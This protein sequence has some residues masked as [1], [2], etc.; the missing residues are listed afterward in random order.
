MLHITSALIGI[1]SAVVAVLVMI[2]VIALKDIA[3]I[4]MRGL[5]AIVSFISLGGL[6]QM[7]LPG[8]LTNAFVT[9]TSSSLFVGVGIIV[10][11]LVIA[12]IA[13]WWST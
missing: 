6:V 9:W 4:A 10:V 12:M 13:K 3:R 5:V 8:L 7:L 11:A 1:A 2:R